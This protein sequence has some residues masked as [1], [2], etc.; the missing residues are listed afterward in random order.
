MR[1]AVLAGLALL[2]GCEKTSPAAKPDATPAAAE[3]T[4]AERPAVAIATDA[5]GAAVPR[6]KGEIEP[7]RPPRE[8]TMK[9]KALGTEPF[10]NVEIR[11]GGRLVHSTP[12]NVGGTQALYSLTVGKGPLQY[13]WKLG[14]QSYR[15]VLERGTCSDGMSDRVYDWKATLTIDG[16][17]ERGCAIAK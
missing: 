8:L 16:K 2:A 13:D 3:P 1:S 5:A 12:E 9:F 10:W 4:E 7:Q 15:L 14:K 11:G 17:A 6:P